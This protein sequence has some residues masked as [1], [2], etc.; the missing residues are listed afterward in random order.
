[1]VT[2]SPIWAPSSPLVTILS[3]Q[4][5]CRNTAQYFPLLRISLSEPHIYQVGLNLRGRFHI[6]REGPGPADCQA[7]PVFAVLWVLPP[8]SEADVTVLTTL[9]LLPVQPPHQVG[10]WPVWVSR[11]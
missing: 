2:N 10:F 1:M 6:R 4:S 3:P 7:I 11:P 5:T 8:L 9:L